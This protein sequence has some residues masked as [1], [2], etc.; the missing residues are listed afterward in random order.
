MCSEPLDAYFSIANITPKFRVDCTACWRGYVGTWLIENDRLYL[1]DISAYLEDGSEANLQSLFP[2]A[3]EKVFADWFTGTLRIPQ[4]KILD[5]VH[6]GYLSTY[7]QDLFLEIKKGYL[8]NKSVKK[9]KKPEPEGWDEFDLPAF[10]R[11]K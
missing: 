10:L 7:E 9:N 6:G 11:K 8:V 2:L 4:G 1:V 3:K 5:Y